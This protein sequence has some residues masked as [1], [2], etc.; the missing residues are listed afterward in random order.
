MYNFVRIL[1]AKKSCNKHPIP[2]NILL[3]TVVLITTTM[4][5]W[6]TC[7]CLRL[8]NFAIW[9]RPLQ[10]AYIC[11]FLRIYRH[12]WQTPR[13]SPIIV[14]VVLVGD[15]RYWYCIVYTLRRAAATW[16]AC[17]Y[18]LVFHRRVRGWR[19]LSEDCFRHCTRSIR[20]NAHS[21]IR[22][23]EFSTSFWAVFHSIY[24][25]IYFTSC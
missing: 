10:S 13:P 2:W 22:L 21:P 25:L 14:V 7:S 12:K 11:F 18:L 5:R 20:T 16:H 8:G 3:P 23:V 19:P 24:L 9:P 1:T 15:Y 4:T 17:V 6:A